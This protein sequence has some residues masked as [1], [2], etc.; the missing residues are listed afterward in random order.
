[1][2]RNINRKLPLSDGA[3]ASLAE[4]ILSISGAKGEL[5]LKVHDTVKVSLE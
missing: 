2:A 4:D 3:T 1:M 5:S